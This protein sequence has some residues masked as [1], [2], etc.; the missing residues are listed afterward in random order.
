MN[1]SAGHRIVRFGVFEADFRAGE[2]RRNGMRVKIQEKPF[3]ILSLLLEHAGE[4]VTRQE[5]RDKL[6]S[7]DTFL[8]FDHSLGTAVGKLRQALGASAQHPSLV[9]TVGG[10]GYRFIAAATLQ[11]KN[12]SQMP[13]VDTAGPVSERR[14]WRFSKTWFIS[15]AALAVL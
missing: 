6:W 3:Q 2:L 12:G 11:A 10:R 5:L 9:E 8:D 14:A 1:Q 7:A 15:A 13:A 4:V